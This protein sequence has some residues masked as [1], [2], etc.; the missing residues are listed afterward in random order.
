VLPQQPIPKKQ[1]KVQGKIN[2]LRK[3]HALGLKHPD[4]K[5]QKT[6]LIE[7]IVMESLNNL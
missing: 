2:V 1:E 5:L 7:I 3:K 6:V 4:K